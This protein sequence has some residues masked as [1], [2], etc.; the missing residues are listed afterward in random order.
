VVRRHSQ[1]VTERI[2][3]GTSS[4]AELLERL[5]SDMA[6]AKVEF[7]SLLDPRG[8][9]GRAP[10]QVAEFVAEHVEPIRKRYASAL[11]MKAEL[12]V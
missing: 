11:G 7:A 3:E 6:F 1:A 5:K 4:S 12:F 8:Y 9:V 10:E 2:K